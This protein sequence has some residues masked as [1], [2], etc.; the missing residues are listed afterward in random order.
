MPNKVNCYTAGYYEYHCPGCKHLHSIPTN[1]FTLEGGYKG[2]TWDF[3][4]DLENPT[5]YPSVKHKWYE[6]ND[7]KICHYFIKEGNV[8]FCIDSTHEL[9]GKT[10]P[11][12][13]FE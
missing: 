9:A 6:G 3:N 12:E 4:G 5:F 1:E 7:Q 10:V 11:L 13:A 8:E 2:P